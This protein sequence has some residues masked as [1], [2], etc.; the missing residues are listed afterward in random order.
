[1]VRNSIFPKKMCLEHGVTIHTKSIKQRNTLVYK[2]ENT[3]QAN[4]KNHTTG[5]PLHPVVVDT[6]GR[7]GKTRALI[8][9]LANGVEN[10]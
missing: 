9:K 4:E 3:R 10:P 6:M 5:G 2:T 1:M 7:G 8:C